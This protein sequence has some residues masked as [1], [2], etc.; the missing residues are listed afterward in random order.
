MIIKVKYT[1]SQLSLIGSGSSCV[2]FEKCSHASLVTY[3][4]D[5]HNSEFIRFIYQT[6]ITNRTVSIMHII[7]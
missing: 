1:I 5:I 7:L 3:C 6:L 4:N 2:E